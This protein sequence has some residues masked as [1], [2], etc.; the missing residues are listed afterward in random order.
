MESLQ[1]KS[2]SAD[3]SELAIGENVSRLEHTLGCL[4]FCIDR[5]GKGEG[6]TLGVLLDELEGAGFCFVCLLLAAPF[7]QPMSLGP[8]TMASGGAFILIGWQMSR[9]RNHVALPQ[10]IA[11][12]H[13]HGR[14]W[15]TLL[16]FC[17]RILLWLAKFTRPRLSNWVDGPRGMKTVGWLIFSGGVLLTI[18]CANLPFNNTIP[19]LMIVFA[20]LAWLEKDGLMA[21]LSVAWGIL[22]LAYFG[23]AAWVIFW[24]GTSVVDWA[25]GWLN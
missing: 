25:K 14:M 9:G 20:A 4:D 23:L 7:I 1:E 19:A 6:I 2:A 17:R 21:V 24:V 3:L 11:A 22:T 10:K 15:V 16:K 8:L 18:P 13:L 5:A 12:W